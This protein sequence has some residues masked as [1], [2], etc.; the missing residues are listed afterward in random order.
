MKEK[1]LTGI[2][3][4]VHRLIKGRKLILGGMEIPYHKGL[5]GHSDGDVLSH[6]ISDAILTAAG[7]NDIGVL[8]P[9]TNP[10]YKNI[11]SIII[12][13]Q[14][15][16]LITKKHLKLVNIS[17]VLIC[18]APKLNPYFPE[19]KKN[20]ARVLGLT[21]EKIGLSAKTTETLIFNP[22]KEAIAA[23]AISLLRG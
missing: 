22:R 8:F 13:N 20:L 12:L 19:I 3:F 23:L 11:S 6:A 16:K 7:L 17:A 5:L 2:G 1:L 18:E 9:D 4:D 14:V 10:E 21:P 15:L